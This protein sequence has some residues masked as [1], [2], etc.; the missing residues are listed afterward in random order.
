MVWPAEPFVAF[1]DKSC[2]IGF[3]VGTEQATWWTT[4]AALAPKGTTL[5]A[6]IPG[7]YFV[8]ESNEDPFLSL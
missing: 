3:E 2:M 4:H 5:P 6:G 7:H 1:P 8:L